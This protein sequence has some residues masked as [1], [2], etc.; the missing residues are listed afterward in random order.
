MGQTMEKI[1]AELGFRE[2]RE[3]EWQIAIKNFNEVEFWIAEVFEDQG[4]DIPVVLVG[5]G[6][7]SEEV[8]WSDALHLST[9]I[10][11]YR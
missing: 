2:N 5:R 10:I 6:E 7:T 4:S 3:G 9:F 11:A 1:L 8:D